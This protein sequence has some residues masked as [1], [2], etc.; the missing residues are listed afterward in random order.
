[1]QLLSREQYFLKQFVTTWHQ[2]SDV[3]KVI[4]EMPQLTPE[5]YGKKFAFCFH[6]IFAMVSV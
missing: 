2:T 4:S 1:M 6:L 5:Q 3:R